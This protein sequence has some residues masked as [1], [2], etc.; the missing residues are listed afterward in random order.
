MLTTLAKATDVA[1]SE[2]NGQAETIHFSSAV[3]LLS[4]NGFDVNATDFDANRALHW[5]AE[6]GHEAVARLLLE[7]GPGVAAKDKNRR[8]AL[9]H[10]ARKGHEA[11]ARLLLK[12]GA[13]VA[14]REGLGWT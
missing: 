2:I 9:H 10:T 7:R 1:N 12:K 8:T 6:N 11:V 14:A 4:D 5:A 13:D 3:Q